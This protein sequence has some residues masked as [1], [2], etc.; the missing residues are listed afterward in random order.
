VV[1]VSLQRRA[2]VLAAYSNYWNSFLGHS[3]QDPAP[4]LEL[5]ID[6]R[7]LGNKTLADDSLAEALGLTAALS[8]WRETTNTILEELRALERADRLTVGLP[9]IALN[10]VHTFCNRLGLSIAD[11]LLM[12][13]IVRELGLI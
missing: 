9:H 6:M 3:L 5:D 12:I 11:E 10:F 1:A 4:S 8:A 7:A 13:A 2:G